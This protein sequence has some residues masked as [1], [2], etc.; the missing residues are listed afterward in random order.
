M[1]SKVTV[2]TSS[3]HPPPEHVHFSGRAVPT[4][5]GQELFLLQLNVEGIFKAKLKIITH[6]AT[7]NKANTILLQEMHAKRPDMLTIPGY[8]LAAHTISDSYGIDTFIIDSAKWHK[9]AFSQPDSD[10][11]W[12]FTEV[13]GVNITNIYKPPGTHFITELL[14]T[15]ASQLPSSTS[16]LNTAYSSW[17]SAILAAV[18]KTILRG[19]QKALILT[20]DNNCQQMYDEFTRAAPGDDTN[21]LAD[22]LKQT[23]DE[24]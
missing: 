13:E 17:C 2:T 11:E 24:R 14:N 4:I 12:A 1:V 9:I 8:S 6:L 21:E 20:W 23:L 16:D 5:I 10:I 22:A 19:C 3:S 15:A 18:K 7:E